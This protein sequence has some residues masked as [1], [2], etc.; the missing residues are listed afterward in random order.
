[1]SS[2]KNV[3]IENNFAL[4][5]INQKMINNNFGEFKN[6]ISNNLINNKSALFLTLETALSDKSIINGNQLDTACKE[7]K[8][9]ITVLIANKNNNKFIFD[10]RIIFYLNKYYEMQDI[11][12]N[13]YLEVNKLKL[14]CIESKTIQAEY[15]DLTKNYN[16]DLEILNNDI[17]DKSSAFVNFIKK[18]NNFY[19]YTSWPGHAVTL[20][21]EKQVNI[22]NNLYKIIFINAGQGAYLNGNI[23][24]DDKIDGIL[25]F[26]DVPYNLMTTVVLNYLYYKN[27]LKSVKNISNTY[28]YFYTFVWGNLI[29]KVPCKKYKIDT[30]E[31]G[32]CTFIS[33]WNYLYYLLI[34]DPELSVDIVDTFIVTCKKSVAYEICKDIINCD[35]YKNNYALKYTLIDLN[36][37]IYTLYKIYD[38][39]LINN[40]YLKFNDK[41]EYIYI[42][43]SNLVY[44]D[45]PHKL[46][47]T[48]DDESIESFDMIEDKINN[49]N[50]TIEEYNG[51][52]D[53]FIVY[54]TNVYS[55]KIEFKKDKF[56]ISDMRFISI[57]FR[58]ITN[59]TRR[60][61]FQAAYLGMIYYIFLDIYDNIDETTIIDKDFENI[62]HDMDINNIDNNFMLLFW[63]CIQLKYLKIHN[64]KLLNMYEVKQLVVDYNINVVSTTFVNLLNKSTQIPINNLSFI[65]YDKIY[66]GLYTFNDILNTELMCTNY[67]VMLYVDNNYE[68]L[69]NNNKYF[70][71]SAKDKL[72]CCSIR[73]MVKILEH[74]YKFTFLED[75]INYISSNTKYSASYISDISEYITGNINFS[76]LINN[77]N[78]LDLFLKV[79]EN[80]IVSVLD[81]NNIKTNNFLQYSLF[82]IIAFYINFV[83][84]DKAL[85]I[86]KYF[87]NNKYSI[88]FYLE[89]YKCIVKNITNVDYEFKKILNL[90]KYEKCA[91]YNSSI[92]IDYDISYIMGIDEVDLI[93][94]NNIISKDRLYNIELFKYDDADIS[95]IDN[96]K[97]ACCIRNLLSHNLSFSH[98]YGNVLVENLKTATILYPINDINYK[99]L[100][101]IMPKIRFLFNN[102]YNF[103]TENKSNDNLFAQSFNKHIDINIISKQNNNSQTMYE[104]IYTYKFEKYKY[105]PIKLI[106][107]NESSEFINF[108]D[109]LIYTDELKKMD[110]S[111]LKAL[112]NKCLTF[113]IG[114][115]LSLYLCKTTINDS[116]DTIYYKLLIHLNS[117]KQHIV[118]YMTLNNN[119]YEI[120]KI[121]YN[122][123][124]EL[125]C[126]NSILSPNQFLLSKKN[127]IFTFMN[128]KLF[129]NTYETTD[130]FADTNKL[131]MPDNQ[132]VNNNIF[133]KQ[134]NKPSILCSVIKKDN[135]IY[136]N[137]MYDYLY[138]LYNSLKF[139]N[140]YIYV[141]MLY[142]F[143][144]ASA[145][146]DDRNIF[147]SINLHSICNRHL[148]DMPFFKNIQHL[149]FRLGNLNF[150]ENKDSIPQIEMFELNQIHKLQIND[151]NKIFSN[152]FYIKCT[153]KHLSRTTNNDLVC[154]TKYILDSDSNNNI[155]NMIDICM[156]QHET[157]FNISE[158]N[159]KIIIQE[160][161]NF[162]FTISNLAEFIIGYLSVNKYKVN[163]YYDI[164]YVN[165][166][167]INKVINNFL[168]SDIF[169]T[170]DDD[171]NRVLNN[172]A[173]KNSKI[174]ES[175]F[176]AL[177]NQK[178]DEIQSVYEM[179]MGSGKSSF[180]SPYLTLKLLEHKIKYNDKKRIIHVMPYSLINQSIDILHNAI[181]ENGYKTNIIKIDVNRKQLLYSILDNTT[182]YYM[183]SDTIDFNVYIMSDTSYKCI[184]LN[185]SESDQNIYYKNMYDA[186]MHAYVI[187]DEV[188]VMAN[189][190]TC[191]LNYPYNMQSSN[192]LYSMR[193]LENNI[194]EHA[195]ILVKINYDIY[196]S[197]FIKD[198]FFDIYKLKNIDNIIYPIVDEYKHYKQLKK[199]DN[200]AF[201]LSKNIINRIINKNFKIILD[202]NN[203]PFF[204]IILNNIEYHYVN[205]IIPFMLT[206]TYRYNFGIPSSYNKN[207]IK[208]Y[209]LKA[210]PYSSIDTPVYGSEFNDIYLTI[211]LTQL[212]YY[213][214]GIK[215]DIDKK[216]IL[217]DLQTKIINQESKYINLDNLQKTFAKIVS[218]LN[219]DNYVINTV[220]NNIDEYLNRKIISNIS[221]ENIDI[222]TSF[223]ELCI[224][225]NIINYNSNIYTFNFCDVL[226]NKP[227]INYVAFTGTPYIFLPYDIDCKN[228]NIDLT[229]SYTYD[230][231]DKNKNINKSLINGKTVTDVINYSVLNKSKEIINLNDKN[232]IIKK[233]FHK[234][235]DNN[236]YNTL[237]DV[238]A[239]FI[240]MSTYNLLNIINNKM[241]KYK[242]TKFKYITYFENNKKELFN[243][244]T[245][246]II[247]IN[248]VNKEDY[249]KILYYFPNNRITGIDLKYYMPLNSH[250]LMTIS[251]NT[252]YRDVAQGLFRL[253]EIHNDS[254]NT[255]YCS[256]IIK[257]DFI[258]N[259][260]ILLE[261]IKTNELIYSRMQFN[262]YISHNIDSLMHKYI[263]DNDSIRTN[264]MIYSLNN[265]I[266]PSSKEYDN[267]ILNKQLLNKIM[268][269]IPKLNSSSTI[270]LKFKEMHDKYIEYQNTNKDL[271]NSNISVVENVNESQN[272]AL[273]KSKNINQSL[274][275][276]YNNVK[277][278]KVFKFKYDKLLQD[279]EFKNIK[280]YNCIS[281]MNKSN[282]YKYYV[283][284]QTY[285][286]IKY[287]FIVEIND[288]YLY[289]SNFI[290]YT[291]E[292]NKLNTCIVTFNSCN[293]IECLYNNW[294]IFEQ[295]YK[296][297]INE[298]Y[299]SYELM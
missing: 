67:N 202:N 190:L 140:L 159:D 8:K 125:T 62:F 75:L 168:Y 209:T 188:D 258:E 32:S 197:Y 245:N 72:F 234:L 94:N 155:I 49:I 201:L 16:K 266:D 97:Y 151:L 170:I 100:Y 148:S 246:E 162:G 230:S 215:R 247:N 69:L 163:K 242:I 164:N 297:D 25:E 19:F 216:I 52:I 64:I 141:N 27:T 54:M 184:M 299:K 22:E 196:N 231:Y 81:D 175:L 68:K 185:L 219:L 294:T 117:Y 5:N 137:K 104:I 2:D 286:N 83:V 86:K 144:T 118:V 180:I 119:K 99:L 129:K 213:L 109:K 176:N 261:L 95:I 194:I 193:S 237:I 212:S 158:Y 273:S 134:N 48:S 56:N 218:L 35:L 96:I 217:L 142:P 57:T 11:F 108:N 161:T 244:N 205:I 53:D 73:Y 182:I 112:V 120:N 166:V 248:M 172:L 238:G 195:N 173:V 131:K 165:N 179:I 268:S 6:E 207:Y 149:Y 26:Y 260:K 65:V 46:N 167:K 138:L 34:N 293:L 276:N 224:L 153:N 105:V 77:V 15:G 283:L 296:K 284:M 18:H 14:N 55:G 249:N 79:Y 192:S 156:N 186:F 3:L 267:D 225:E 17:D 204:H 24:A 253:R 152:L 91:N 265:F 241:K 61:N 183:S 198:E 28:M 101:E 211:F 30:Q 189:P 70:E 59:L 199:Y 1:M 287:Y 251:H 10:D 47:I 171:N 115:N 93:N 240:G 145:T 269:I 87:E 290:K 71:H 264:K 9:I 291:D 116:K 135:F 44:Y 36:N 203:D 254:K 250:G 275:I 221:N 160:A 228:N 13:F 150:I 154:I 206:N 45:V 227:N 130:L 85:Q 29:N 128:N 274:N 288:I 78:K 259:V 31:Y 43:H 122:D 50:Y 262:K 229:N 271:I 111:C 92:N 88:Q 90:F 143:I 239:Y 51:K 136:C 133:M 208:S 41:Y 42:M 146:Y 256:Y 20:I 126:F 12:I 113:E 40:C 279:I 223:F 102:K 187:F 80:K 107:S 4:S 272:I 285:D 298:I 103:F 210:I 123:K 174:V 23:Y 169:S 263:F 63:I 157:L 147:S 257:D 214:S 89:I 235:L 270:A 220:I 200:D 226:L 292:I 84:D 106:Y 278:I 114:N 280:I 281:N 76:I 110:F 7:I 289:L 255:Q 277:D 177:I 58:K 181:C 139:K 60:N 295:I 98:I 232:T 124:D 282:I 132:N 33:N 178:K 74:D 191:E 243:C 37:I 222:I 233:I 21:I 39:E 127:Y 66:N 252:R 121:L 236:D 38:S 82:L